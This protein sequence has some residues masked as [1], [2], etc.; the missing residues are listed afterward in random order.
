MTLIKKSSSSIN[1][2]LNDKRAQTIICSLLEFFLLNHTSAVFSNVEYILRE[3]H[4]FLTKSE[5]E[6]RIT[7]SRLYTVI[8]VLGTS[9]KILMT[10]FYDFIGAWIP[11]LVCHV[12]QTVGLICILVATP[13]NSEVFIWIGYPFFYGGGSGL[14]YSSVLRNGFWTLAVSHI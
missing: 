5:D 3:Q 12:M 8:V 7:F 14:A 13:E 4:F 11:R 1:S 9:S 2:L 10:T 6:L